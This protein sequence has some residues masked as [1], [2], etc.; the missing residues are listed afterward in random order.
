M[1]S[2]I[3]QTNRGMGSSLDGLVDCLTYTVESQEDFSDGWLPT[4]DMNL[5]VD[6]DNSIQYKFYEKPTASNL[7]LKAD[8]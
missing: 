8:T 4:L 5:L 1:L 6:S 7:C 2:D 3:Q